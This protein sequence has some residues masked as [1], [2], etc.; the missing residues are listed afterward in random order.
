MSHIPRMSFIGA[1]EYDPTLFANLSFPTGIVKD[2]AVN[3]FLMR[4]GECPMLFT[5]LRFMKSAFAVWSDKWRDGIERMFLALEAEYNPLHNFDRYEET[6]DTEE[7]SET[8]DYTGSE[9]T[10]YTGSETTDYTGSE[11]NETSLSESTSETTE[12][13]IS[14]FNASTY[15]PNT[16]S[17][18]ERERETESTETH[19]R[20]LTDTHRQN[21]TDAHKR[22]LTDSAEGQRDSTHYGH[23]YGNIGV[24]TSQ[25]MLL[26]ELDLRGKYNIYDIIAELL[27]SEFCL[28]YY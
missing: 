9:T 18:S 1:Y 8:T 19:T 26:A 14:A 13:T 5:D 15:Q 2:L 6:S 23:L 27:H 10:D 20:N 17:D 22:N 21:L 28:Y 3:T 11:Q 4:Y 25:Q 7:T 24:T 16:N 12:N